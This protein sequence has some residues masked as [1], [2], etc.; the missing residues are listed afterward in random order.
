MLR[1]FCYCRNMLINQLVKDLWKTKSK[2]DIDY[3]WLHEAG[4]ACDDSELP[5]HIS[6]ENEISEL[7]RKVRELLKILPRPT[8][9]TIA[10]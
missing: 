4:C 1:L 6:T 8:L 5:H 7:M 2:N 10:R 9:V 3:E